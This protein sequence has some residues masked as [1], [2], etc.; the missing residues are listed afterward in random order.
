MLE[1]F[2]CDKALDAPWSWSFEK[3]LG[4][5]LISLCIKVPAK[6]LMELLLAVDGDESRRTV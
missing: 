3:G 5:M 2:L 1:Q 4:R 6:A